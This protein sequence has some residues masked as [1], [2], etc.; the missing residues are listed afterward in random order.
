M[1]SGV[2]SHSHYTWSLPPPPRPFFFHKSHP[3]Y[4][5]H[6]SS[7]YT[8]IKIYYSF[9]SDDRTKH[10]LHSNIV[11]ITVWI[12]CELS[13]GVLCSYLQIKLENNIKYLYQNKRYIVWTLTLLLFIICFNLCH[14]L[15]VGVCVL[16][17]DMKA[18]GQR[19]E[20][21]RDYSCLYCLFL[22]CLP[23]FL[24]C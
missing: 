17:Q 10:R 5:Q 4:S 11:L 3:D 8:T 6:I 21:E 18:L 1:R 2:P 9:Y 19:L 16:W 24:P 20:A 22:I 12:V 13:R 7:V 23:H 15:V 14:K